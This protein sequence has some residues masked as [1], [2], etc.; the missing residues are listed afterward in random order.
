VDNPDTDLDGVAD[1]CDC[2]VLNPGAFSVPGEIVGV[3]FD[4]DKTTLR[5]N[6]AAPAAGTET[7]HDVLRGV[8]G[9]FPVGSSPSEICL[10]SEA[11]S[12]SKQD[13][14]VP[15]AGSGFWYLVRGKN[16]CGTGTYGFSTE[17]TERSSTA[18]P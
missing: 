17:G 16:T 2:A 7:I 3:A 9:G 10:S 12:S 11:P 15:P 8:P 5:W 6:S 14:S 1:V 18:C 4:P 13:P